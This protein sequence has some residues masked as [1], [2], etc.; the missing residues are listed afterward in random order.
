MWNYL[1][2]LLLYGKSYVTFISF[3]VRLPVLS[4][5]IVMSN[6]VSHKQRDPEAR[7]DHPSCIS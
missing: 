6:P 1:L 7:R 5:Q 3:N 2:S 4:M